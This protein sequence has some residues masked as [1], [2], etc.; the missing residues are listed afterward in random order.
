M[1]R[2]FHAKLSRFYADCPDARR[3]LEHLRATYPYVLPALDHV[4]FRRIGRAGGV[5]A[6]LGAFGFRDMGAVELPPP[7]PGEAP[8]RARWFKRA[9]MPLVFSSYADVGPSADLR[10]L[11]ETDQYVDWALRWGDDVNHLA[12]D[13][14]H[15]PDDLRTVLRGVERALDLPMSGGAA[16][17]VSRDGLLLQGS[18][19]ARRVG[20][21]PK[22]FV[23][24]VVRRT[25]PATGERRD[26]F[27]AYNAHA[28]FDSTA[29]EQEQQVNKK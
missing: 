6:S 21:R 19:R 22:A 20:G 12:L 7:G 23:E 13:L 2:F 17:Q 8:R 26:G 25:D 10:A 3:V 9:S 11:R 24:F 18:S 1:R 29:P 28:I 14:S 5:D 16:V 4:A 27:D 15:Y